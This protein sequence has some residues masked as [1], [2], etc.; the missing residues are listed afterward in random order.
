MLITKRIYNFRY[1]VTNFNVRSKVMIG[2]AKAAAGSSNPFTIMN[3]YRTMF[4]LFAR[5]LN[6]S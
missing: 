6:H 5:I 3:T 4:R 1:T 2:S